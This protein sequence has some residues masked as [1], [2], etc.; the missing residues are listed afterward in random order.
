M[1][2]RNITK[3]I[4]LYRSAARMPFQAGAAAFRESH[5]EV[6]SETAGTMA[7]VGAKVGMY[8]FCRILRMG[9]LQ[10]I[11]WCTRCMLLVLD[12]LFLVLVQHIL[13]RSGWFC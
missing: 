1:A 8:V 4:P 11:N 12:R 10:Q 3:L 6:L 13:R 2:G 5:T 7:G 9:I